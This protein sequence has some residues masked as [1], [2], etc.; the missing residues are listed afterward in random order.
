MLRP[1]DKWKLLAMNPLDGVDP[2]KVEKKEMKTYDVAQT[3]GALN[4]M[5]QTRFLIA[6]LLAAMCGSRRGEIAG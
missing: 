1:A 4:E 2:P 3:V 5:R 6:Y